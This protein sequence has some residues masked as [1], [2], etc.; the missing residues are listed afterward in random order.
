MDCIV[1]S[2]ESGTSAMITLMVQHLI[3]TTNSETVPILLMRLILIYKKINQLM[4]STRMFCDNTFVIL[5]VNVVIV[6]ILPISKQKQSR[7][8]IQK[9]M[10][11]PNSFA[12]SILK[13]IILDVALPES[14]LSLI[15]PYFFSTQYYSNILLR[16]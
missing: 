7:I 6:S 14:A 13:Y 9:T 4:K 3:L 1:L 2:S 15:T 11:P 16:K 10:K 8:C 5:I 12:R